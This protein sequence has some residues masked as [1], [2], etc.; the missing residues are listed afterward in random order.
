MK[1]R[2]RKQRGFVLIS[3]AVA[4]AIFTILAVFA[5]TEIVRRT[6]DATAEATGRYLLAVR[7]A[8]IAF[9]VKH[10]AWLLQVD[11][12]GAP[13]GIYPAPPALTFA[14]DGLGHEVALADV[15][16]LRDEGLLPADFSDT[17]PFGERAGLLLARSGPCPGLTCQLQSFVY[18]CHPIS[19]H[20]ST[21]NATSSCVNVPSGRDDVSPSLLGKVLMSSEGY[22]GHD[23]FDSTRFQGP[24]VNAPRTWFP[25]SSHPGRAVVVASLDATP[26]AQFV[27]QGDTRHVFLRN[28]LTVDG[29]IQTNTGLVFGKTVTLGD[30][31]D[32]NGM[33]SATLDWQM[34]V[35]KDGIWQMEGGYTVTGLFPN[36]AH[37]TYVAPPN[38]VAPATPYQLVALQAVDMYVSQGN[39]MNVSGTH[40]GTIT[41]SGSV[42]SS[43]SV[44][45]TGSFSGT[46]QASSDSYVQMGQSVNI[47]SNRVVISPDRPG[48]RAS[49]IQGC[50]FN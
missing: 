14:P 7:N 15:S 32:R 6:N 17:M 23:L 2:L 42:N 13:A 27:R 12:S 8:L 37:N 48:S 49:L 46:F 34:A 25:I 38:C 1:A 9:Q 36:L 24:L 41:G 47:V 10:E 35:C 18:S 22:G 45:V 19:A 3:L 20:R 21:R 44:S 28:D 43:G 40:S 30:A 5:S 29:V 4:L 11:T 16:L 31:C 50:R 39:G 26:F 33:F